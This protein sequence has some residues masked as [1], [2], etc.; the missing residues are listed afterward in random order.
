MSAFLLGCPGI[1]PFLLGCPGI[2]PFLLGCPGI[3]L[4]LLGCPGISAFLLGCPISYRE[5][6]HLE[7]SAFLKDQIRKLE[8]D[9]FVVVI[10]ELN[11]V[12]MC[13]VSMETGQGR[14]RVW[15]I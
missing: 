15:N 11:H 6:H 10:N 9:R 14:L 5:Q 7:Q 4:F 3:S 13:H 12:L 1:S 2:S 8:R